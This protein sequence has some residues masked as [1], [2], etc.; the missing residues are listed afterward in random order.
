[1]AFDNK[2]VI[3]THFEMLGNDGVLPLTQHSIFYIGTGKKTMLAM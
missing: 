2:P 3:K 1:M